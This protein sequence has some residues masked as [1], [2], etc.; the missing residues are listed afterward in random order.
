MCWESQS[1]CPCHSEKCLLS[2]QSSQKCVF[3]SARHSFH[4]CET[5]KSK[6]SSGAQRRQGV[7][8]ESV[9]LELSWM[10]AG[11]HTRSLD[12]LPAPSGVIRSASSSICLMLLL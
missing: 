2:L 3:H 12:H 10:Q 9:M 8:L 6:A 4:S 5:T 11:T 7:D 1:Q